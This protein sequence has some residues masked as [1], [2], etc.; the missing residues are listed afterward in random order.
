M[1]GP[2]TRERM[3]G[4]AMRLFRRE[5]YT[6]TSWRRLVDEAG[7][8][9]GSAYHHFPGG[10]E[11]LGV[12]A[13]EFGAEY[14]LTTLH[15]AFERHESVADAVAWWYRKAGQALA[16][17]GY[18][19]GCPIATLTLETANASPRLTA[20]CAKAFHRWHTEVTEQLCQRGYAADDA[21]DLS[22]AIM[23][24]LQG[25]LLLSRIRRDTAPLS[26]AA[27]HVAIL[28]A[29]APINPS[30]GAV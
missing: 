17:D 9:W 28:L 14:V 16:A 12:A 10:K 21:E 4:T 11:E 5:G 15:R 19:D 18:R 1:T 22:L 3:I 7:T 30:P 20:A 27:R 23:N 6:A 26:A 29:A 2:S 13:V 8:P 24:N 25:A